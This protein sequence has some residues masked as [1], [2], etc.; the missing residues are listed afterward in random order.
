M[1]MLNYFCVV[2]LDLVGEFVLVYVFISEKRCLWSN[3]NFFVYFEV[4]L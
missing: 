4:E 3:K 2:D 1:E